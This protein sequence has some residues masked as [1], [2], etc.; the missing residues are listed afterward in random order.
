MKV[1]KKIIAVITVAIIVI[2]LMIFNAVAIG[3]AAI[4]ADA[5]AELFGMLLCASGVATQQQVDNMSWGEMEPLV[6][7]GISNG[8]VKPNAKLDAYDLNM[9][10]LEFV[11]SP[12]AHIGV[13]VADAVV[14]AWFNS[15]TV[16]DVI[17]SSSTDLKGHGAMIYFVQTSD[18][19]VSHPYYKN[20]YCDYVFVDNSD[21]DNIYYYT[22]DGYYIE[23]WNYLDS[24]VKTSSSSSNYGIHVSV[25]SNKHHV[26]VYGDVRYPDGSQAVTDDETIPVVGEDA[27]GN[28]VSLDDVQSG[29]VP[30]DNVKLDFDKFDDDAIIDLLQQILAKIDSLPVVDTDDNTL[31]SDIADSVSVSLD[32]SELNN[33]Q[34]PTGISS[35]FPFCLPFDFVRGLQ[36]LSSKPVAPVFDI[37]FNIPSFGMFPGSE[38]TIKLDMSEYSKYFEVLRWVQVI[39]FSIS[40]CFISYRLVQ[41]VH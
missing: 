35:V 25:A 7:D 6:K 16:D 2:R 13:D 12:E 39:I 5:L 1:I 20:I 3:P 34:V 40:L 38:N 27:S 23:S 8:T 18:D 31:T 4:A 9:S 28:D 22:S 29:A 36:L 30:I 17:S 10:W 19:G 21:P 24:T 33:L 14:K 41:G 26:K 11:T 32:I 15:L 37:P